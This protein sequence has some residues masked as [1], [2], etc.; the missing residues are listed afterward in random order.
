MRITQISVLLATLVAAAPAAQA[1]SVERPA[2]AGQLKTDDIV[3]RM[4][5]SE[6]GVLDR[7]KMHHP[8]IEVYI[9]NL[10]LDESRGWLPTDDNYFLGQFHFDQVPTLRPF[11][12]TIKKS[13]GLVSRV[14]GGG[15][16]PYLA[17]GFAAMVAP[18]WRALERNRYEF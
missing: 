11:S 18:D 14:T 9:Q 3:D 16:A 2:A 15:G 10:T 12:Q 13:R 6:K 8:L 4:N 17:D 5:Q 7:L 1:Q